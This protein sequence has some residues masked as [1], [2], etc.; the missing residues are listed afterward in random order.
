MPAA[1]GPL[2]FLT[3]SGPITATLGSALG[4]AGNAIRPNEARA[5][6]LQLER[7]EAWPALL[8]LHELATG[9][10]IHL[11]SRAASERLVEGIEEAL[12]AGRLSLYTGWGQLAGLVSGAGAHA[13]SSGAAAELAR[14]LVG[15]RGDVVLDGRQF[16][17]VPA[18]ALRDTFI[19]EDYQ[20]V[21]PDQARQLI[22]QTAA[23]FTVRP[24]V[25]ERWRRAAALLASGDDPDRLVLLRYVPPSSGIAPDDDAPATTPSQ[26]KPA[27]ATQYW[28]EIEMVYDDGTPFDGSAE[29]KLP[30]GRTVDGSPDESG[31][32][33]VDGLT[34]DG[35]CKLT[36]PDLTAA[37]A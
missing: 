18:S 5:I 27:V 3:A 21:P 2:Q 35:D 6:V 34:A 26:L 12:E 32:V 29:L 9:I 28:I 7:D 24:E 1:D 19:G 37:A 17:L 11:E 36:F 8:A 16:R 25:R 31:L 10:E 22:E 4:A 33:R 13:T 23:R 20:P 14:S 30:D 15:G